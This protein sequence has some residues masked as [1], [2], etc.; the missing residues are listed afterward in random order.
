MHTSARPMTG[1][2][3]LLQAPR[4]RRRERSET[5]SGFRRPELTDAQRARIVRRLRWLAR[6][7]DDSIPIPGT[8]YSIGLD[9][10]LG[11]APGIGDA[12]AMGISAYIIFEGWRLGAANRTLA[13]MVLNVLLDTLSGS[14]PV[15]GDVV[16]AAF[17]ANQRNLRLLGIEPA[18]PGETI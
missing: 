15:V 17:K 4:A 13:A 2:S 10:L 12:A 11:L 6:L 8:G 9:P 14:I 18:R 7:L 5:R 3:A 16:D 1:L